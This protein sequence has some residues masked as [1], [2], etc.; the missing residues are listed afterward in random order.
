M[1]ESARRHF[2]LVALDID[3]TMVDAEDRVSPPLKTMLLGLVSRGIR[4]VLCTGRRWRTVLPVLGQLEH[5]HP[6]AVCCGGA[7][8]KESGSNR[9][10]YHQSLG[11][12]GAQQVAALFSECGLVPIWLYDRS[13]DK[14]EIVISERDMRRVDDVPYLR[15]NRGQIDSFSNSVPP[16]KSDPLEVYTV[17][18]AD[19]IR[20]AHQRVGDQLSEIGE[21]KVMVQPHYGRDQLALEVHGLGATKWRAL[22]WVMARWHIHPGEVLAVGD[23]VNDIPM[24][25][26][27]GFSFAMG[28]AVE[29]VKAAADAVT[30]TNEEHGA[31]KALQSV[32]GWADGQT[33]ASVAG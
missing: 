21:V 12:G 8:V 16:L 18:Y 24:L 28:N 2:K 11:V 27:A 19:K 25:R 10:L 30:A 32:F 13:L 5:A 31:A 29:E 15:R 26:G 3:G 6:Y 7:L 33:K 14:P 4:C 17:D 1:D 23:D 20:S 22:Q 9:T